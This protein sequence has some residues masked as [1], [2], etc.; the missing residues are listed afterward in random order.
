[1]PCVMHLHILPVNWAKCVCCEW[2][3]MVLLAGTMAVRASPYLTVCVCVCECPFTLSIVFLT[4]AFLCET[5]CVSGHN[6]NVFNRYVNIHT[7]TQYGRTCLMNVHVKHVHVELHVCV[8]VVRR[9]TSSGGAV[10]SL[11]LPYWLLYQE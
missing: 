10:S 3:N 2:V 8:A 5:V 1:M 4:I 7:H 11:W 9:V 6:D